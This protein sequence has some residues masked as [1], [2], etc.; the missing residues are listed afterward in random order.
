MIPM[1]KD[2]EKCNADADQVELMRES[3]WVTEDQLEAA[4]DAAAGTLESAQGELT[5]GADTS[6]GAEASVDEAAPAE[7]VAAKKKG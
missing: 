2:G 3:G 6:A 7:P 1:F 5:L 4:K